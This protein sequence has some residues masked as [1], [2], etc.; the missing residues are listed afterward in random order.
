MIKE[1]KPVYTSAHE[2]WFRTPKCLTNE[3]DRLDQVALQ[4]HLDRLGD[5]AILR[6]GYDVGIFGGRRIKLD[7][8]QCG[9]IT[10]LN[11][12][13]IFTPTVFAN[14]F[15]GEETEEKS[16]G[17]TD[18]STLC[19][20]LE[21]V[22][23]FFD[24]RSGLVVITPPSVTPVTA[25]RDPKFLERMAY[26]FE[27]P[28]FPEP[29]FNTSEQTRT[30]IEKANFPQTDISW[31]EKEYITLYSPAVLVSKQENGSSVL[32]VS[33]ER[34][35]VLNWHEMKT[36]T[37]L[38]RSLDGGKTWNDLDMLPGVR[39]AYLF[40]V[41][42]QIY[43]LGTLGEKEERRL[44]IARLDENDRLQKVDILHR[45]LT[46]SNAVA[47]AHGRVYVPTFPFVMSAPEDS[48]LLDVKSWSY[49][50]DI[51]SLMS[52]EWYENISGCKATG[53]YW[54]LEGNIVVS[55]EGELYDLL[56]L[57]I[58]PNNG[59]AGLLRLTP[60]GKTVSLLENR[61]SL[62]EMPTSVS[63]FCVRYD[64]ATG[65]YLTMPSYPSI[66]TPTENNWPPLA[67]QRNV[68][69]LAASKDLIN[70][71]MLDILLVDREVMNSSSSAREHAF[72]YVVWDFDGDD[73]VYVVR[74]TTGWSNCYHDGKYVTMYRLENYQKIVMERFEKAE[75]YQKG[76]K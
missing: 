4:V 23:L 70:W 67:G 39:W 59:W 53:A 61:K 42:G 76:I 51:N 65:L 22:E 27:D 16:D 29:R 54:P 55:P 17:Y 75:F 33:H 28:A 36:E 71:K 6:V 31:R 73:L 46:N 49:S 13:K 50:N 62:V 57:E 64:P 63:K 58:F 52:R 35:T 40:E 15:F 21:K 66:P 25:E 14:L 5:G 3:V 43:L 68:L 32:Y 20:S 45:T 38:K 2:E 8:H 34:S 9:R 41:R 74:E 1:S 19:E 26:V 48:D 30:V 69:C 7:P 11:G 44:Q 60:D 56:R 12:G 10:Y 37:V 47:V 18:I 72:Q 24:P